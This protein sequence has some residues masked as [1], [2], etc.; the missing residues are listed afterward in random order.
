MTL[1]GWRGLQF[2]GINGGG[3]ELQWGHAA[4]GEEEYW[5]SGL[6]SSAVAITPASYGES[7]RF[8][9][10]QW[11]HSGMWH[12]AGRRRFT[13][14]LICSSR[15]AGGYGGESSEWHP[16]HRVMIFY[17]AMLSSNSRH[18]SSRL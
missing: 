5:R 18:E 10:T 14:E 8:T 13:G 4:V 1:R 7:Q 9:V 12:K 6:V 15:K 17:P 11:K 16:A 2:I 3:R